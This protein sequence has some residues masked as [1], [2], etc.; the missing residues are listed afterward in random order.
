MYFHSSTH[1]TLN[2]K[3]K[4][5]RFDPAERLSYQIIMIKPLPN[6]NSGILSSTQNHTFT[7]K[8]ADTKWKQVFFYRMILYSSAPI[9]DKENNGRDYRCRRR[10]D[11]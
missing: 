5:Y 6:S 2:V 7:D 11:Q 8:W 3:W 4:A 1:S 10:Q 9:S